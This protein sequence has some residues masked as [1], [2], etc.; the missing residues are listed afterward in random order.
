MRTHFRDHAD[1]MRVIGATF[2]GHAL[3]D[4]PCKSWMVRRVMVPETGEPLPPA[5]ADIISSSAYHFVVTWLPGR[6]LV[7]T[8]DIGSTV[9]SGITHLASLDETVRLVREASFDY[10]TGKSTHRKEY[11][12]AATAR[13]I[14]ERAYQDLRHGG[15]E[16]A[17]EE[18][19]DAIGFH[20]SFELPC[21]RKRACRALLSMGRDGTLDQDTAYEASGNDSEFAVMS[22][23]AQAHWHY[24]AL[25]TWADLMVRA[26][27]ERV[28]A[29]A[30]DAAAV[31]AQVLAS[32]QEAR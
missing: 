13:A 12:P 6:A 31:K 21:I 24:E 28:R 19:G 14:I 30:R 8:G 3:F 22:W 7:V 9:Y 23:P 29:A 32:K 15:S 26:K 2:A 18:I 20:G 4:Q 25:R 27:G 10:L 1:A 5:S 16:T 17:F 11:D